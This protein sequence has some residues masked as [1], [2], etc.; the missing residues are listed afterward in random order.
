MQSGLITRLHSWISVHSLV[1]WFSI[2]FCP[3][4]SFGAAYDGDELCGQALETTPLAIGSKKLR[5]SALKVK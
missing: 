4:F 1:F 5:D 2:T 3:P